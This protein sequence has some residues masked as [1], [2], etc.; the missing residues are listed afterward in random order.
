[1]KKFIKFVLFTLWL[2][3][4]ASQNI[5]A[6]PDLIQPQAPKPVILDVDMA[7]ED[8]FSALFLLSHPN[9]DLRAITVSGTGEAHCGPGVANALGLVA[10]SGHDEIPVA[11]GRETPLVGDHEFPAEWRQAADNAY[12]VSIPAGGAA[13]SLSASDLIVDILRNADEPIS[14]VAV[15]PLTNIAEAIQ[16][17]PD[18]TT[19]IEAIYIM[20]GAV[21]VEG[22]VGNSGV[23]IQNEHAEWNIYI[24]P[25]AANIVFRSG[26]PVILVPLDATGDV[27]VTRN[28]YKTLG[29][30]RNTPSAQLV[31]DMLTANLGFVDSG[32]FQFWDSL[33]AA[34]FTDPSIAH[35]EE[36]ELT[37]VEEE[38]SDSGR[39]MPNS[40][41]ATIKVAVSADRNRFEQTLLAI[42]NWNSDLNVK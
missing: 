41:G 36:M 6:N 20:G 3:G 32:G 40:D 18:I 27:P 37:V 16:K 25:A 2:T 33:T 8:M 28:F 1:M 4:C 21:N 30:H 35:F 13:S 42:W 14:I 15:G 22:N 17:E 7:H 9:A 29:D 23:G 24:D 19:N 38:G 5:T 26:V 12:G 34:I 31:Y 39:T 10:L 11:C